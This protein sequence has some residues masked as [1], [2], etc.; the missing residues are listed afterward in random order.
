V[1]MAGLFAHLIR[2]VLLRAGINEHLTQAT[3]QRQSTL[4]AV[5]MLLRSQRAHSLMS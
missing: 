5:Q 3:R 2:H 1:H 4:L